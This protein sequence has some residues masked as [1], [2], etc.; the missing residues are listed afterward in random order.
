LAEDIAGDNENEQR[1][2]EEVLLSAIDATADDKLARFALRLALAGHVGIPHE[3]ELDFL[4]EAESVFAPPHPKTKAAA[5]KVK[6]P[7]PIE[8]PAKATPK[9]K[10]QKPTSIKK[11]VAA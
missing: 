7:T 5:K 11:R 10:V 1:S 2:A 4:T 6:Q 3:G 8:S 9:A